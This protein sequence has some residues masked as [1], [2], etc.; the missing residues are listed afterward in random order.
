MAIDEIGGE[1]LTQKV[2]KRVGKA[3]AEHY[4]PRVNGRTPRARFR[5]LIELLREEGGLLDVDKDSDGQFRIHKRS[6]PFFSMY[7]ESQ[8]VCSVDREMMSLV[9]GVKLRRT[10]CRHEGDPCCTFELA[11]ECER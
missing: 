4:R 7:E 10:A 3:L 1:K 5:Q 11:Q 2:L 6:C 8:N 9:V